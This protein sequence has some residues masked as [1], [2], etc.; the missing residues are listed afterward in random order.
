MQWQAGVDFLERESG[1]RPVKQRDM[2]PGEEY[3]LFG[4]GLEP[5]LDVKI[6]NFDGLWGLAEKKIL[7]AEVEL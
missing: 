7:G 2:D 4:V 5:G 6:W 1:L 3:C